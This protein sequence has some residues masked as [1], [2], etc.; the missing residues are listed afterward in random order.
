MFKNDILRVTFL[1][2]LGE[3]IK[4]WEENFKFSMFE[5]QF[6]KY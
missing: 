1:I 2:F 3:L 4:I 6:Y 5:Q